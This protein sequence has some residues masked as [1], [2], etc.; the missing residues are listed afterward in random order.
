MQPLL[1]TPRTL[2]VATGT[3]GH[4]PTAT[5]TATATA[6][7]GLAATAVHISLSVHRSRGERTTRCPRRIVCGGRR[8]PCL[9]GAVPVGGLVHRP[10]FVAHAAQQQQRA[11]AT[12]R[13]CLEG[14]LGRVG[15]AG[16]RVRVYEL[17]CV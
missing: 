15:K 2:A 1:M 9:Q 12:P 3:V 17:L 5:A 14:G 4:P 13:G 16:A 11:A 7:P 6:T 8:G 10:A